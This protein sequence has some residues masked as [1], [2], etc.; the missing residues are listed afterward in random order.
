MA[1]DNPTLPFNIEALALLGARLFDHAE[2]IAATLEFE[3]ITADLHLAA[4]ACSS[5]ASLQFRVSE[6]TGMVFTQ[7]AAVTRR[8]LLAALA[9]AQWGHS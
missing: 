3:P 6:I 5:F 2:D 8:D 1:K 7:D 9:D 4:R